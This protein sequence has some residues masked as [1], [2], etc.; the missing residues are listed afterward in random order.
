MRNANSIRWKSWDEFNDQPLTTVVAG[1]LPLCGSRRWAH[2]VAARRPYDARTALL[3][4]SDAAFAGLTEADL[5]EALAGHPRI[6]DRVRGDGAAATLSRSEQ[7]SMADADADVSEA[8]LRG[9]ADYE[10]KFDRVFLIRAAGRTP[11][12]MLGELRRRLGNNPETEVAEVREQ[13][14]QIT[15]L[16]LEGAFPA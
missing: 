5:A 4:A 9:S 6:G 2:E 11:Q 10:S 14:R 13:L 15:T 8:I 12:E 1:L 16:R 7:A 3:Q